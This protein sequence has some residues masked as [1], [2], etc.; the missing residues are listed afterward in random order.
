[1]TEERDGPVDVTA[2]LA[3]LLAALSELVEAKLYEVREELEYDLLH[4]EEWKQHCEQYWEVA[5]EADFPYEW[6]MEFR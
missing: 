3:R 4:A 5:A 2:Q 1:M 6:S